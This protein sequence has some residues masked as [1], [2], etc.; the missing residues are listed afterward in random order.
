MDKYN[1]PQNNYPKTFVA[2]GI[3]DIYNTRNI[4]KGY[5]LGNKSYPFLVNDLNS[6][7]DSIQDFKFAEYNLKKKLS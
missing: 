3:I 6:D 7:I 5:L 1:M 4:L 2:N